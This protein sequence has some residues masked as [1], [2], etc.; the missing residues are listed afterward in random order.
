M[1]DAIR[2]FTDTLLADN[3]EGPTVMGVLGAILD[4]RDSARVGSGLGF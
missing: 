2:Q 4:V 1:K 3:G